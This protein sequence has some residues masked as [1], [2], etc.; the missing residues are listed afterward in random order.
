[1]KMTLDSIRKTSAN[2]IN[3]AIRMRKLRYARGLTQSDVA[4]ALGISF[5]QY[6]KYE[7]GRNR[8]SAARLVA[9][10]QILG[11]TPNDILCEPADKRAGGAK[12]PGTDPGA[13]EGPCPAA[14]ENQKL[15]DLLRG[16]QNARTRQ[17]VMVLMEMAGILNA[18][19][20]SGVQGRAE[21]AVTVT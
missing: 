11:V 8:I 2:D 16:I 14:L 9:I 13:S 4:A 21:N 19:Q 5:Q 18:A 7:Q 15:G 3:I 6:Q 10:A 12:G 20:G 17:A 1:M